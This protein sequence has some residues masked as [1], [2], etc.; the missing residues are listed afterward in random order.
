MNNSIINTDRLLLKRWEESDAEDLYKY[1]SDPEVGP[2]AGWP[3]HKSLNESLQVITQFFNNDCS[4]AIELK[5]TNEVIGCIGYYLYGSSNINIGENDAE[6]GYWIG[7]PYWNKGFCTEALQAIIA[8]CKEYKKFNTLWADFFVNNPASARVMEKCNFIDTGNINYC[9]N[10]MHGEE[11]PIHIMRLDL[12]N[13][14]DTTNLC[15]HLKKKLLKS[16]GIYFPLWQIIQNDKSLTAVVR[17]RQLHIYRNRK[18]I[19]IL[20]GKAQ[21]KIIRDDE[22]NQLINAIPQN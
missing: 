22:I 19:L 9:S 17:S 10:L 14:F 20:S 2:H 12:N 15:S 13:T 1:A 7:R 5:E 3:T 16:D 6:I 8:Y 4:W 11:T 21:P 18:K